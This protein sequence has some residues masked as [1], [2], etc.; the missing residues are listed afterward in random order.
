M[1]QIDVEDVMVED[2]ATKLR[3][4]DSAVKAGGKP[5]AKYS[6]NDEEEPEDEFE[7]EDATGGGMFGGHQSVKIG[8]PGEHKLIGRSSDGGSSKRTKQS[9]L[10]LSQVIANTQVTEVNEG[11]QSNFASVYMKDH[12]GREH[13]P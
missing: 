10:G 12:D 7:V 8:G 3:P 6:I 11:I 5:A 9:G 13:A 4:A 1:D 2:S